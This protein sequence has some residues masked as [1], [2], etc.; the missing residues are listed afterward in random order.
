MIHEYKIKTNI[1]VGLGGLLL[2]IWLLT[3]AFPSSDTICLIRATS[4]IVGTILTVWGCMNY[5]A[6]KGYSKA[7]GLVALVLVV[8]PPMGLVGLII[9]AVL[10]DKTKEPKAPVQP[11]S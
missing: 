3:Q 1:G 5:A 7:F 11:E 6:A 9:L 2:V 10:P 8:C 4:F